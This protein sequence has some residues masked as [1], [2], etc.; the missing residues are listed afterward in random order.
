MKGWAEVPNHPTYRVSRSGIIIGPK[1]FPLKSWNTS[2]YGHQMVQLTGRVRRLV[3]HIVLEAF[4]GPCPEGMEGCHNDGD[5]T[6]NRVDNLRWDTRKAN[7]EDSIR[8]GT[9]VRG[10]Q[11]AHCGLTPEQVRNIRIDPRPQR[12]IAHSYGIAQPTVSRIKRGQRH[13]N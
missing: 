1:G 8:H 11:H 6:N 7:R 5:P 13:G 4:V 10:T 2:R 3:H 9:H 12:E